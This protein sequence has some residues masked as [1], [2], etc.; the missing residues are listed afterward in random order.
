MN[1]ILPGRQPLLRT[2]MRVT[3]LDEEQLVID[4]RDLRFAGPLELTAAAALTHV[5]AR[6]GEPV[7]LYLP[8]R[9]EV[10]SYAQRM[11]LLEHLAP[12]TKVHGYTP[13]EVRN[14]C[15]T[16]LLEVTPLNLTTRQP[17]VDRLRLLAQAN[18]RSPL[19]DRVVT[20]ITEL[21]D[22]A[23]THGHSET[24]AF[25][26]AQVYSGRTT[27]HP[28]L[29]VAVCDTGMGVLEHLRRGPHADR[30]RVTTCSDSL[31]RAFR[32]GVTGTDDE[33]GYGLCDVFAR[34]EE[35][36]IARVVLRSGDGLARV[37]RR[38]KVRRLLRRTTECSTPGTWAWARVGF[39][40]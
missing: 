9:D 13:F 33:R 19:A 17:V 36:G 2:E 28:R 27:R 22:N 3:G 11:D 29:E 4:G 12:E 24:G 34:T 21:V 6:A 16:R 39:P 38:G 1:L 15:S 25:I 14:D 20:G 18:F 8:N 30:T 31:R 32:R 40:I 5:H 7:L 26:A 37:A 23:V 10:T 35:L